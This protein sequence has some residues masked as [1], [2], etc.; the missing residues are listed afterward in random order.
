VGTLTAALR[1]LPAV[2]LD[3]LESAVGVLE[4][5]VRAPGAAR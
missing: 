3:A 2:E 1:R 5:I 4:G